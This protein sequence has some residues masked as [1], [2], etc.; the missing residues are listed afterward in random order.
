MTKEQIEALQAENKELAQKVE[1]EKAQNKAYEMASRDD[2]EKIKW[3]EQKL[4]EVTKRLNEKPYTLL[5][6]TRRTPDGKKFDNLYLQIGESGKFAPLG[7]QLVKF[8]PKQKNLLLALAKPC[9]I[10]RVTLVSDLDNRGASA[11]VIDEDK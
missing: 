7:I 6:N 2:V 11:S 1:I 8:N 4:D 3:L 10:R 5:K 9:E